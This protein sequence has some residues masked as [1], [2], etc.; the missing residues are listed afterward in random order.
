MTRGYGYKSALELVGNRYR[1]NSRQQKA[2]IRISSP[3]LAIIERNKKVLSP[4][5]IKGKSIAIDGFNLLILLESA[6]CGAFVFKCRDGTYRDISSVHGSYKRVV[7]TEESILISG[8]TLKALEV[9]SIV[10]YLDSPVSNSG[11]LKTFLHEAGEKINL[12]WNVQLVHNPDKVLI[13]L[14][15]V[16]ASSDSWVIDHSKEWFN[17]G[18]YIIEGQLSSSNIFTA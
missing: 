11:R 18:K 7:K 2:L 6:L 16:V 17:L 9:E 15:S 10:W 4:E 14:D 12:N 13:D 3:E 8:E 1:L 5:D